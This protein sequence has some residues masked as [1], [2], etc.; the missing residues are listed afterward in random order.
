MVSAGLFFNHKERSMASRKLSS[1]LILM[2]AT[3]AIVLGIIHLYVGFPIVSTTLSDTGV[4]SIIWGKL[5]KA[6]WIIF[7]VHLFLISALFLHSV[8][9]HKA[10]PTIVVFF[11]GLLPIFDGAILASFAPLVNLGFGIPGLFFI[12]GGILAARPD[13]RQENYGV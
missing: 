7:A 2:G 1:V 10:L 11:C 12:F 4:S 6:I 5:L 9:R 3:I 13:L 8:W